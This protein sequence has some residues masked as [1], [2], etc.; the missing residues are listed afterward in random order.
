M[1]SPPPA[2]WPDNSREELSVELKRQTSEFLARVQVKR[3]DSINLQKAYAEELKTVILAEVQARRTRD[4]AV[5]RI[6]K[7]RRERAAA[8]AALGVIQSL[9]IITQSYQPGAPSALGD[10]SL[11]F[12]TAPGAAELQQTEAAIS[13][14]TTARVER[15]QTLQRKP[16]RATPAE[17]RWARYGVPAALAALLAAVYFIPRVLHPRPDAPLAQSAPGAAAS[18]AALST[19]PA[20][21]APATAMATPAVAPAAIP[22]STSASNPLAAPAAAAV[23]PLYAADTNARRDLKLTYALKP[24][25]LKP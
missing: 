25:S 5:A 13:E 18:A 11:A 14:R 17:R 4:L 16:L 9:P 20:A 10:L 19:T 15:K 23:T 6:E 1:S 3:T 8:P 21:A 22:G 7:A 12:P 2:A 24:R